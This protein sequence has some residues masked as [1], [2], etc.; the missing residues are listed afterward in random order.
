[1]AGYRL[2]GYECF[3]GFTVTEPGLIRGS[4]ARR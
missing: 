1:M 2:P 3:L 4:R